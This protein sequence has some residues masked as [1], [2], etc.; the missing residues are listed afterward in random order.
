MV[1]PGDPG[2]PSVPGVEAEGAGAQGPTGLGT[3]CACLS[4][5][6][7]PHRLVGGGAGRRGGETPPSSQLGREGSEERERR[8]PLFLPPPPPHSPMR[9]PQ[10]LPRRML[11]RAAG[12]SRDPEAGNEV[13][14]F[15][16]SCTPPG[17]A[18]PEPSRTLNSIRSKATKIPMFDPVLCGFRFLISD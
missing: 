14:A 17:P 9:V 2:P 13:P 4:A 7:L 18:D 16:P 5:A 11:P 15:R 12:W 3:G 10:D 8:G 1:R 6:R